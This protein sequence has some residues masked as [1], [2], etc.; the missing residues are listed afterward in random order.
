MARSFKYASFKGIRFEVERHE[1]TFKRNIIKHPIAL[2]NEALYENNGVEDEGITIEGFL[3]G[4]DATYSV[5]L[6]RKKLSDDKTGRLIHPYYGMITVIC[7]GYSI[8]ESFSE[9]GKV[10]LKLS[11]I[12]IAKSNNEK[13]WIDKVSDV[14]AATE[15]WIE[16]HVTGPFAEA[17]EILRMPSYM[18]GSAVQT[19]SNINSFIHSIN[20]VGVFADE[21]GTVGNSANDLEKEITRGLISSK[22]LG[23]SIVS[24]I[25]NFPRLES[26]FN[27][28]D[29]IERPSLVHSATEST[30]QKEIKNQRAFSDLVASSAVIR[31]LDAIEENPNRN[32]EAIR[33]RCLG[34]IKKLT[35]DPSNDKQF[36]ASY[37]LKKILES[38]ILRKKKVLL[39]ISQPSLVLAYD[40]YYDLDAEELILE[41]NKIINPLMISRGIYVD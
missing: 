29:K 16:D 8:K 24:G 23:K 39:N 32:Y 5:D 4:P 11:F 20:G 34:A 25:R 6:L 12:R 10:N 26:S 9:T 35:E 19:I 13:D 3:S 18:V 36:I 14:F 27:L 1:D 28:Y 33:E 7:K 15:D 38:S 17:L 22:S 21:I 40:H 30:A 2:E 31:V 37:Q 41:S